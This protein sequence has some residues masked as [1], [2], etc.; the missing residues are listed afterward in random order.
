MR[1][2]PNRSWLFLLPLMLSSIHCASPGKFPEPQRGTVVRGSSDQSFFPAIPAGPVVQDPRSYDVVI[3][4]GGV[5]GLTAALY[6]TDQKKSVLIIEKEKNLG[7][8]AEG[9]SI[10]GTEIRYG[11]GAAYWTD[12]FEE[13]QK[14]FEHIGFGD[15]KK[16]N[17]IPEPTDAYVL[18]GKLYLGLWENPKTMGRLPATFEVFKHEL[19]KADREK[20]IPVQPIEDAPHLDLDEVSAAE[21]IRQMPIRASFRSGKN[22]R[23]IYHRFLDDKRVDQKDPMK[24]V[25][26]FADLY[27]RSALGAPADRVSALAF[28]NFYSAEVV[29]R[30]STEIGTGGIAKAEGHILRER[31]GPLFD[32]HVQ[33]TV[34]RIESGTAGMS[35]TYVRGGALHRV[36]SKYVIY[37][38]Q[39]GFAPRI[40]AG[41]AEEDPKRVAAI[42][43]LEYTHFSVHGVLV[44]G[45]PYR[46]AYDTWFRAKDYTDKDFTD[47]VAGR[48]MDPASA[49]ADRDILTIY[50][51]L[52]P[53]FST[54]AYTEDEAKQLAERSVARLSELLSPVL[55]SGERLE[56]EQIETTRWPFSMHI[57]KPGHFT[58]VVPILRRPFGKVYFAHNNLGT[59]AVEEA[60]FRGHCAANNVLKALSPVFRQESWSKCRLESTS[61]ARARAP[62]PRKSQR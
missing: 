20:L 56:V 55:K 47:V 39:L 41:L 21:W 40:I 12:T 22:S 31:V 61:K 25:V 54:L 37:A 28:A 53:S 3:V 19:H 27:C 32:V 34:T 1:M 48:W 5:S 52:P 62:R 36:H 51:P 8:P 29:P 46:A 4:G 50:Q 11:R 6:L 43:G 58:H 44:K 2:F 17:Q 30:Y 26:E 49:K 15:F 13:Q 57:A 38:A 10:A 33:S 60:L 42:A 45:H 7:G 14:I 18:N 59:P 16:N 23:A 9:G 24:E 35:T